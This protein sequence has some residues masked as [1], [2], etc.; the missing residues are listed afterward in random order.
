MSQPRSNRERQ[1][2][3]VMLVMSLVIVSLAVTM[4]FLVKEIRARQI[5]T[6][7]LIDKINTYC[8]E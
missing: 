7:G 3:I 4:L 5:Y 1:Y 8:L 6:T 2:N